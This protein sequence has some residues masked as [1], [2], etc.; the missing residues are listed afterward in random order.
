MNKHNLQLIERRVYSAICALA[1]LIYSL[2]GFHVV[3][4]I[5]Y[6]PEIDTAIPESTVTESIIDILIPETTVPEET[7]PETTVPETTVVEPSEPVEAPK[8]EI[9][10][11]TEPVVIETTEPTEPPV[12]YYDVPLSEDLQSYIFELCESYGVDPTIIIG[13]IF[14][15][16]SFRAHIVGDHGNSLG[17]MQIQPRWFQERMAELG[18]TNLLDPYQNV[19]LGIDYVAE[20]ISSGKSI[21]WVLMAYN[22]GRSYANAKAAEGVVTEYARTILEYSWMLK[23]EK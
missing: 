8:E 1:I 13:M 22:G 16:S 20:L 2:S 15:E 18:V 9:V 10:E 3:G 21:E 6:V 14:R 4:A 17:L 19:T 5:E 7:A 11:E 12:E 23:G